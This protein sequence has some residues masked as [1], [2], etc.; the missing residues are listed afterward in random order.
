[1]NSLILRTA[2][3]YLAVLLILFSLFILLR[4][5]NEPGGGFIGGLLAGAA[6]ALHGLADGPAA[7]R[8]TLRVDPRR[9]VGVGLLVALASG[10]IAWSAG[11]PFLTGLWLPFKV[12]AIGKVGTV[13]LFD[14]GVYLTVLGGVLLILLAL[15]E[16]PD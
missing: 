12:P 16:E 14:A 10:T 1:M 7:A 2:S 5:H 15:M 4:G 6:F 11:N 3:R 9:L 13:L 8:R